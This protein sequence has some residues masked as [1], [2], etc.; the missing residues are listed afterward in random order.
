MN[1]N[2]VYLGSKLIELRG[3]KYEMRGMEGYAYRTEELSH[4][5]IFQPEGIRPDCETLQECSVLRKV[6]NNQKLNPE[7]RKLWKV[8]LDAVRFRVHQDD[9]TLLG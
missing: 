9:L 5:F 2:A 8:L 3:H 4:I 7:E 1:L 6:E